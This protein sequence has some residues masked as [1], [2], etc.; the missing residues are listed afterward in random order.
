[1]TVKAAFFYDKD[2]RV[3]SIE[4]GWMQLAFDTLTELFYR[5]G[6]RKNVCKNVGIMCRPCQTAGVRSDEVYSRRMTG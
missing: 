5:V 6:L 1:M 3:A 4:L 2:G